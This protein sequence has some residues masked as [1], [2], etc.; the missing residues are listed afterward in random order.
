MILQVYYNIAISSIKLGYPVKR[1]QQITTCMIE[2][3]PGVSRIDKL[4]V[5]HLFEADYNLILKIMWS[6]RAIWK[7]NNKNLLND[8]Q[9]GSKPGSRAI[10]VAVHKELRYNY[11]KLTRTPLITIDNDAKSCFD[12]IMCNV[13]MLIS[14]YYGIADNYCRLQSNKLKGSIFRLRTGIGDSKTTYTNTDEEP[15][16]GTGQGSCASPA[17]WLLISSFIM[18]LLQEN[19]NGMTMCDILK[20]KIT[21]K[22]IEGFVD[23]NSNFTNNNYYDENLINLLKK[24]Q[25]DGQTW[26]GFL[27]TTGGELELQKCF[28]YIL[29]WN[30]DKWGNPTPQ[31]IQEQ[32]LNK[33]TL[34][35]T[36]K[37]LSQDLE[38]K[39]VWEPH[40]TLGCQ[41]CIVGKEEE[42][43]QKLLNKSNTIAA[44]I[45]KAQLNK[46][47]ARLAYSCNYIPSMVY[48]LTAV[49]LTEKQL[50][51]I[52]QKATTQ[53][54]R[55]SGFEMTTPKAVVH[56][57]IGFG[58]IGLQQL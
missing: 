43:F 53:L 26:E 39:E 34:K 57:P 27:S 22:W 52:Q 10:D 16:Y 49:S 2:K 44:S 8:G 38:Q 50:G 28:Y 24:A 25:H 30:W 4:R 12:R 35:L 40:K 17:I 20:H 6:R 13:A 54:T 3:S 7:I 5:I 15:I 48:C 23:D 37:N 36:T 41:K 32:A 47:Q 21:K 56:G 45:E 9:S 58:G 14:K 42:Q 18:D 31:S 11:S 51:E 29:S 55:V 1:W 46:R 33:L 19:A